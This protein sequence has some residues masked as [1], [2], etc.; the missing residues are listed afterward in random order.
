V[1]RAAF[2]LALLLPDCAL[3]RTHLKPASD[4]VAR[5]LES[6][7]LEILTKL[8]LKVPLLSAIWASIDKGIKAR[9]QYKR[10]G[11]PGEVLTDI[12]HVK[13]GIAEGVI[14]RV[15]TRRPRRQTRCKSLL[16]ASVT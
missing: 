6:G 9:Q 14:P 7:T 8:A 1:K 4:P 3:H 12:G 15:P 2:L 11:T 13:L 16:V 10:G 5:D